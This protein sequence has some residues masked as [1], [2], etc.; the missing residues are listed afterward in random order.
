VLAKALFVKKKEEENKETV[1]VFGR[2]S[3]AQQRL[4]LRIHF[5][6]VNGVDVLASSSDVW[7]S[8]PSLPI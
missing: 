4:L 7:A 1:C 2:F 5:V 8:A 6:Q 3:T